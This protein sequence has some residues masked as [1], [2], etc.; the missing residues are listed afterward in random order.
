MDVRA[1]GHDEPEVQRVMRA[2][3]CVAAAAWCLAGCPNVPPP[4]A[5]PPTY[6]EVQ[7]L[8]TNSCAFG[9]SCHTT[10]GRGNGLDL[11]DPASHRALVN[12]P[13]MEV[14]S[15]MLVAPGHPEQSFLMFKLDGTMSQ[16]A[17]CRVVA[18]PPVCG[19][20]MPMVAGQTIPE[21]TRNRIREWIRIGAPGPEGSDAGP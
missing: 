4:D 15:M 19:T 1:R 21:A 8:F 10:D 9:M 3:F 6:R 20:Q 7:R 16:I 5:G 2:W 13:S 17:E 12:Q 18:D 14:P 11:S